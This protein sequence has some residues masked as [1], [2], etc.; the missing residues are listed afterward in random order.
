MMLRELGHEISVVDY[1]VGPS[2]A[3]YLSAND[4]IQRE[5]ILHMERVGVHVHLLDTRWRSVLRYL[6]SARALREF[7]SSRRGD[8]VL[9][10]YGGGFAML[11]WASRVRPF[12]VYVVGSDVLM[13]KGLV[14]RLSRLVLERAGAVFSNGEY[15]AAQ[16]SVL[17]PRAAVR[18][19]Y[20]GVRVR[21]FVPTDHG[22][23]PVR[24]LCT[25]GFLPVYNNR[26][27]IA[28]LAARASDATPISTTFVSKGP[29]L[30]AIRQLADRELT[31]AQRAAVT[32]A[33]GVELAR[34]RQELATSHVYVSMAT[35][36]GTSISLLEALASG[37]F[38]ILS[39]IPQNREW[40]DATI[41]NGLLVPLDDPLALA[42][43]IDRA[44]GDRELRERAA[45]VNRRLVAD[46][47]DARRNVALLAE[48]LQA[49]VT[50]APLNAK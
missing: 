50:P 23:T 4:Q 27:V 24:V 14:R 12:A 43:A 3:A 28:G 16:T 25:R 13:A 6:T 44:V 38:P 26:Y 22:A 21:D 36:D 49:L 20:L 46:R 11:A 39:D 37:L 17:A 32:F 35:S 18:P 10:L 29:E 47:A 48:H 2:A 34:L 42:R 40:I 1:A 41:P 8:V 30:E 9:T 7:A 15:L 45:D 5:E 19:L 33:G 31:P